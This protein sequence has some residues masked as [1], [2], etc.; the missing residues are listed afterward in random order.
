[1]NVMFIEASKDDSP[2]R[3]LIADDES[4][5]LDEY[6]HVLGAS[7]NAEHGA[8]ALSDLEAE[9][10]GSN[11]VDRDGVNYELCLCRQAN[12]AVEKVEEAV[13]DG[14]PFAIAFLDVRMPPGP[15]GVV[16]A[17][18]IRKLDHHVNIVFVTGYSD[19]PLEQIASRVPPADKLLYL[20]KPLHAAEL[21]QFANALSG[22]WT[23]ERH[24]HATRA[25]LHQILSSTPAVVYTCAPSGDHV[26]TF[27]SDNIIEQ[28]GYT[29]NSF[30]EPNFWLG[31]VHG[32]D[33]PRVLRE[34]KHVQELGEVASEYRFRHSDGDYRWICDRMR[35]VLDST[36]RPKELV[37]CWI[38]ITEQ[39]RAEETIRN[40]AYFDGL[41]GLPN[42]VLLRELLGHALA[43]AERHERSLAVLFLDLDQFK[44]INDTLGHDMGDTLLQ[45]V[46]RRL[47]GCVRRS[48]AIFQEGEVGSL[49]QADE[50]GA[51]SRL[52]G[53]EFVLILSEIGSSEDAANVARRIAAALSQPIQLGPDEVTVTAS[54]GISVYPH[55]ASDAET[56]LKHADAA[57][58][59]AKEQG[60]NSYRFYTEALNERTARRFAI[61]FNLRRALERGE[62]VLFY[63]PR[64][65][66]QAQRVVG[67]EAL[68]RWQRP[69]E[70]LVLPGEF[71][72]VAEENGMIVPIG[73]WVLQEA[74]RQAAAWSASG[75]APLTVSVNISAAQFK[76]DR[77][78]ENICRVLQ[79]TGLDPGLL[80][81]E[82]TESMLIEDTELSATMLEKFK[83]I[84]V[85]ISIDDF[86]TGYSSLSYLKRFALTA[87]KVDQSLIRDLATNPNDSAIVSAAIALAHSLHLRVVAEGVEHE[88]QAAI[89][90]SKG[91]DEAQGYLFSP[92]IDTVGFERWIR[93]GTFPL[94][95]PII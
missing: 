46:A 94:P 69:V 13:R 2:I 84:G 71:I 5:I 77:L 73:E 39:R 18:R 16:A 62:F 32:D 25:R 90:R 27:V 53:D 38:D 95:A 81:I 63:Q 80:E 83:D 92:P 56:L 41:T 85:N 15:D 8:R 49:P 21:K 70:G 3:I 59:H 68:L 44:R 54:I 67:M 45:E 93:Q 88:L 40:L 7:G 55:D 20:Q 66:I 86:G 82:L 60:R 37:G 72:S 17:E 10:F 31:R 24:L 1:V 29:P 43:N 61:E 48:D 74:C 23:A 79:E 6:V 91:C 30:V 42:R 57:M 47:V 64:I 11:E 89:L 34:L 26:A 4:R 87:L 78:V 76:R 50:E 22:K 65:D 33:L 58:Y 51:I 12:E 36:G 28:F 75:L 9:L 52:G 19:T 14:R 35:L